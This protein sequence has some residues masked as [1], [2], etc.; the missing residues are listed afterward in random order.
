MKLKYILFLLAAF[1][2]LNAFAQEEKEGV[3]EN[4]IKAIYDKKNQEEISELKDRFDKWAYSNKKHAPF[5]YFSPMYQYGTGSSTSANNLH[6]D[7]GVI[8]KWRT[9]KKDKW[10]MNIHGWLEQTS[11]WAGETTSD[12]GKK[13]GMITTPN[14][15]SETGHDLSLEQLMT[16]F[17]FFNQKLDISIGKFDPM[18]LTVFTDYSGWDKYN[19]FMKSVASDPVPDIGA[20]MGIYSEYHL[21]EHFS[22]GGLVSDN[23]ARNN[24]L[25]IPDFDSSWNYAGFLRFKIGAGKGLYSSHNLMVYSQTSKAGDESG[26]GFVY[27]ANQGLSEDLILVLKVSNG[28]GNID[29]LNAAYVAGLTFKSPLNR[30]QD[31]AGFALVMNEKAGNYEYALDTYYRYFINEYINVA[32]N[33]QLINTVNDKYNTVFGIRSFIMF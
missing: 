9:V 27:T 17:F 31:Q 33:F 11:F 14:A 10:K 20:G 12:F 1:S 15:S 30:I 22:F 25:Y 21:S 7:L 4:N 32:P 28:T 18:Y 8:Y 3:I 6:S 16:E 29:K 24:Y 19:Y 13:L 26:S 23:D 5:F 2:L